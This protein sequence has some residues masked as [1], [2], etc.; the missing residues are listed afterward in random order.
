MTSLLPFLLTTFALVGSPGPNTLSVAAV[1]AAY[2]RS[3]GVPYLLGICLGVLA[4]VALVGSGLAALVLSFPGVKPV[5]T[6]LAGIYLLYLAYKIA[7]AGPLGSHRSAASLNPPAW[8]AGF[9]LSL[10][11]PKAYA[12][13]AA[14]F[15][16]YVLVTNNLLAD[17][18][19]KAGL[20]MAAIVM[21]NIAWL[22]VGSAISRHLRD[23]QTSKVVNRIFAALLIA[24]VLLVV[25]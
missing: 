16:Q 11:N 3:K 6:T 1:G 19:L 23:A 18:L 13:V 14:V 24:S 25:L 22:L 9:A 17:S 7:T 4:V 12:S 20:F 15:S 21:V 5:V 2:G 8:Y 10:V